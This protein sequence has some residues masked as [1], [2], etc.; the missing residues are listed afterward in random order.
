[1]KGLLK[2]KPEEIEYE[3]IDI[4]N[5]KIIVYSDGKIQKVDDNGKATLAKLHKHPNG[6]LRFNT[7]G[8]SYYVHKIVAEIFLPKPEGRKNIYHLNGNRQDNR[9]R[10]LSYCRSDISY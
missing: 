1:M 4:G 9:V 6:Y 10:N 7:N 8:K 5:N 3:I 2:M